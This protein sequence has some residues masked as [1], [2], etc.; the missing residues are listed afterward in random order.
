M[1]IQLNGEPRQFERSMSVVELIA[2][3]D[4]PPEVVA[5]E[6]NGCLVPRSA[7]TEQLVEDG[8]RVE[9]VTLVGG[10]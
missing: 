2:A 6:L 5:V 10:G 9:V 3:L 8:D 4:L 7:H 1:Q